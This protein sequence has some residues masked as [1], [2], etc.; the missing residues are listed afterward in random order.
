LRWYIY[1]SHEHLE[2]EQDMPSVGDVCSAAKS[3]NPS[4]YDHDLTLKSLVVNSNSNII[5][6]ME[7]LAIFSEGRDK[8]EL[9][10]NKVSSENYAT[11]Y[12]F[13]VVHQNR[14]CT[15]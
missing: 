7:I 6:Y 14:K 5:H 15:N 8:D 3:W 2:L 9:E 11:E 4:N 13:I 1:G 10:R 12:K